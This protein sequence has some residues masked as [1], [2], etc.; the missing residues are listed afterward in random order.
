MIRGLALTA[1]FFLAS[2]IPALAQTHP[3]SHARTHP[4]DQSGHAP[5][6]SA[7]HAAMHALLLGSWKGT[8]RSPQGVSSGLDMSV[9]QDS[10]R[11]V[12]LTMSTDQPIRAGAASNF[13]IDGAKLYW[14]QDLS[15]TSCNVTAVLTDA[16]P[17]VP[18]TMEGKMACEDREMTFTLHKKTP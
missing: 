17:L 15:G 8:F 18:D 14:T 11:R 6:D 3:G 10:A 12:T 4:H 7:Q 2:A 9:A 16:T 5:L 1:S 13:V